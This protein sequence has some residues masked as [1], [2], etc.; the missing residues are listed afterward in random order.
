M[1]T[2]IAAATLT[3]AALATA[4]TACSSSSDDSKADPPSSTAAGPA[5]AAGTQDPAA[6]DKT[7]LT[8]AVTDYTALLFA[9]DS[10][11]YKYLSARCKTQLT[12]DA[13]NTLAKQGHH[14][15]GSQKA[16]G[17]H[18]DQLAGDLAR[19]TYGAGNIPAM[20]R[21]SQP[22]TRESGTWRWDACQTTS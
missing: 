13:W 6:A 18:V 17:I 19:V 7:A 2:R 11:G 14:D 1:R 9:G 15:Y 16:T 21:K 12:H 8:K 4:L 5:P 22:W 10:D 20:E 3:A